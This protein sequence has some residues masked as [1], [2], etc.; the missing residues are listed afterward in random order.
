MGPEPLAGQDVATYISNV[1]SQEITY[2][3]ASYS[4]ISNFLDSQGYSEVFNHFF[5]SDNRFILIII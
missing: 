5:R 4:H 3:E 1:M 2:I